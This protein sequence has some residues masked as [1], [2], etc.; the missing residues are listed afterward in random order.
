MELGDLLGA[1]PQSAKQV[2]SWQKYRGAC[3]LVILSSGSCLAVHIARLIPAV[4]PV[5]GLVMAAGCIGLLAWALLTEG[6]Q[7][8]EIALVMIAC[9]LGIAL[10]LRDAAEVLTL[11]GLKVWIGAGMIAVI[12]GVVFVSEARHGR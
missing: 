1:P 3:R 9:V 2:T 4:A 6:D 10:G 8:L 12:V 7:R 5:V 11:V